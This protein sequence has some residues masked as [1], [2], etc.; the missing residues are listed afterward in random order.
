MV[1]ALIGKFK[2]HNTHPLLRQIWER[3]AKNKGAGVEKSE[4]RCNRGQEKTKKQFGSGVSETSL[5]R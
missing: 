3:S 5:K 1:I 2:L 4:G